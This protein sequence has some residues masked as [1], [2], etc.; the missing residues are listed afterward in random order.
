MGN[1]TGLLTKAAR[2]SCLLHSVVTMVHLSLM[3]FFNLVMLII[4]P[5]KWV[6]L[7]GSE[8]APLTAQVIFTCSEWT[9]ETIENGVK[10]AQ[11]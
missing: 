4:Y 8:Y 7:P 9:I 1:T 11:S 10:C 2:Y 5:V 3:S 6:V